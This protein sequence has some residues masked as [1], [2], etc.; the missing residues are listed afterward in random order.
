MAS[1]Y[2]MLYVHLVFSTKKRRH[3]LLPG[4]RERVWAY[5]AGIAKENR[6]MPVE[7]GGVVDHCHALVSM[8]T[9]L[10]HARLAQILKGGST[11]WIHQTFPELDGFCWQDGY[12]AFSVSRSQV[13]KV[14][15]YI[16]GQEAHH[17]RQSFEDEYRELLKKHGVAYR[18]EYLFD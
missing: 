13:D 9:T 5:I 4:T 6:I 16:R 3:L 10:S 1:T 17:L 8:P 7:I 14:A 15:K 18:E 11:F 12:G 2:S